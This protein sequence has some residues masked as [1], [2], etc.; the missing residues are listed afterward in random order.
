MDARSTRSQITRPRADYKL[1]HFLHDR[2]VVSDEQSRVLARFRKNDPINH[3]SVLGSFI[4]IRDLG[5]G[6]SVI[7]SFLNWRWKIFDPRSRD[8]PT[9]QDILIVFGAGARVSAEFST[10]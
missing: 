7:Q 4:D 5:R 2:S 9:C 6:S 3:P 1:F 10:A 8:R